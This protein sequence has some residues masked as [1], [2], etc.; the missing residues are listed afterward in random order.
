MEQAGPVMMEP[1]PDKNPSGSSE[2]DTSGSS[3]L[4]PEEI[5]GI[6]GGIIS[7]ISVLVGLAR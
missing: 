6:V 3:D 2:S 5:W 7:L 1:T 4:S